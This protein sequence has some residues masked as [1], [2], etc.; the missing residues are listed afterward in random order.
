MR[1]LGDMAFLNDYVGIPY[2]HGGR[3]W[4]ALDCYGLVKL[5]YQEE[6]GIVLRDWATDAMDLREKSEAIASILCTGEWQEVE[7]PEDGDFVVCRRLRAAHHI[8]LFF[9]GGVLHAVQGTGVIYQT[10]GRFQANFTQV[11]F[12]KW[13]P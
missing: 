5:V 7:E 2:K 10:L 6:Y 1:S 8:G 9:G 11:T 12:G 13:T 3:D 4:D